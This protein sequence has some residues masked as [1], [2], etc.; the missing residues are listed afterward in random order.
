MQLKSDKFVESLNVLF[1][2]L[3]RLGFRLLLTDTQGRYKCELLES[4][5]T[6]GMEERVLTNGHSVLS[7]HYS[8]C[9]QWLFGITLGRL[10]DSMYFPVVSLYT[11]SA[12]DHDTLNL[13]FSD[14][15]LNNAIQTGQAKLDRFAQVSGEMEVTMLLNLLIN[16]RNSRGNGFG[17]SKVRCRASC[18]TGKKVQSPFNS[19]LAALAALHTKTELYQPR[20]KGCYQLRFKYMMAEWIFE[21]VK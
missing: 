8:D 9:S 13:R 1:A 16:Y 4:T 10:I 14:S 7:V 21:V 11:P 20:Y 3:V 18:F 17:S 19:A 2:Q 15:A 5:S 6:N 12:K